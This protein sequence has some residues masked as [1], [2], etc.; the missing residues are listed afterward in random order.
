MFN[1]DSTRS[2][3]KKNLVRTKDLLKGIYITTQLI[4]SI[5]KSEYFFCRP[6][7][8]RSRRQK[9]WKDKREHPPQ[10]L[11]VRMFHR[12]SR[13]RWFNLQVYLSFHSSLSLSRTRSVQSNF[14]KYFRRG[15]LRTIV[16]YTVLI[17]S[18]GMGGRWT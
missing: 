6:L 2:K 14:R 18:I 16:E 3:K 1:L 5:N 13:I 9:E 7:H 4:F 12:S 15:Y 11:N 8:V 10:E 17:R